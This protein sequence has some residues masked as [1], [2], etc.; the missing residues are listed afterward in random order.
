MWKY[1]I[2]IVYIVKAQRVH[3]YMEYILGFS[4]DL[5]SFVR[6]VLQFDGRQFC[7]SPHFIFH[8]E[9]AKLCCCM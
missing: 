5:F 4:L 1:I 7:T 3:S 9:K 2:V 8:K 6:S